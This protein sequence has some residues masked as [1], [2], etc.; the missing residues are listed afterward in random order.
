MRSLASA[1]VVIVQAGHTFFGAEA[2]I[3]IAPLSVV[4][5]LITDDA[6]SLSLRLELFKAGIQAI[7]A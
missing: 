4:Q 3:Q 5:R 7:L 1:C 2:G 6:L